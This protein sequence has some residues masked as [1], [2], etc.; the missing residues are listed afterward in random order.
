MI[1][2]AIIDAIGGFLCLLI[3]L[4]LFTIH[5]VSSKKKK[6]WI[7]LPEPLRWSLAVTGFLFMVRGVGLSAA[8][9]PI[10][11]Q[12]I[13]P[14]ALLTTLSLAT[15]VCGLAIWI[16]GA[17]FPVGVWDRFAFAFKRERED[18]GLIPLVMAPDDVPRA[19]EAIGIKV[20]TPPARLSNPE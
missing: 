3:A 8:E 15:T 16:V 2:Q 6:P 9:T 10:S 13:P 11:G 5:I 17:H 12:H 20:M 19:A 7:V 14:L 18:P 4:A 1:S